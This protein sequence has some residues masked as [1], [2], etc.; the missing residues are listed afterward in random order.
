MFEKIYKNDSQDFQTPK[1]SFYIFLE[2]GIRSVVHIIPAVACW[3]NC[4]VSQIARRVRL[5]A[6]ISLV[7]CSHLKTRNIQVQLLVVP[8]VVDLECAIVPA[9]LKTLVKNNDYDW[10]QS[11]I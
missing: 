5:L 11:R 1:I 3:F 9:S 10:E 7:D 6:S 8:S 2:V 4:E